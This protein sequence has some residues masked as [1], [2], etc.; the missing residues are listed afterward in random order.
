MRPAGCIRM[1]DIAS[2]RTKVVGIVSDDSGKLVNPADYDRNIAAAIALYSK[3]RPNLKVADI[4]GNGGHDYDLPSGWIDEFST[5]KG[6]EYPIG[7]VPATMLDADDYEIY[8]SPA[9]KKIRLINDSPSAS[10]SFRVTFTILRTDTTIPDG[11]IDA[12]CNLSAALCLE[13]LANAFAQTSD[14]LIN[15]DS[16]NYRT[17]SDEF[18]RRAKRLMQLYKEHIGIKDD[19]TT[20]ASS[21]I[22]DIP[23]AQGRLTHRRR[24]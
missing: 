22:A 12:L 13:D 24:R 16:V 17:K 2:I 21:V 6:I 4:T 8:Q 15:A 1:S 18:A 5:V 11:D 20:T 23:E 9:A 19:D 7:D 14:S 3:H 10:E